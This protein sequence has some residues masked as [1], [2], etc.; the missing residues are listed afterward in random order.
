MIDLD[1]CPDV[2]PREIGEVLRG[3]FEKTIVKF[4][5]TN[6]KILGC[7]KQLF[8]IQKVSTDYAIH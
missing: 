6:L 5:K 3:N 8:M 7:D 4:I 1:N 2:R